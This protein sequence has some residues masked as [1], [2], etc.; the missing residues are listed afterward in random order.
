MEEYLNNLHRNIDK[1]TPLEQL[2][3]KLN[4]KYKKLPNRYHNHLEE[5]IN[6]YY[7][8]TNGNR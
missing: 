5:I 3:E 1:E 6:H 2:K 8:K 4:I 7:N